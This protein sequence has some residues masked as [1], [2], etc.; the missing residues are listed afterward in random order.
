MKNDITLVNK[1]QLTMSSREI[2]DLVESRHDKVKQS[3]ERLAKR[4][5]IDI[6][7]MGEYLDSLGRKAS[8]YKLVK[9]DSYIVVAQLC[10][11]FTAKLVD[12]W[13]ELEEAIAWSTDRK[14]TVL[15]KHIGLAE[16]RK[17]RA[18][19]MATKS[20]EVI[21]NRFDN[22]SKSSQQVIFAKMVNSSVN[23]ELIPLPI[24]ENKTF[25]AGEVGDLLGV[26][27][28]KIG[29]IAN[30]LNLKTKDY[31]IFVLDKSRSSDKQVETFRYN[32][33]AI[34]VIKNHLINKE[35]A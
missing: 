29:R 14:P 35:I 26:S 21:C 17:A 33:K 24:L 34:D 31:G 27:S 28:N 19:S 11:E 22:L 23:E 10:P 30:K 4:G 5:V 9:R 12:R 8:E 25:S 18:I 16:Y 3:I 6:P 2:A 32:E 7:P 15:P 1:S 20:A 13:Q